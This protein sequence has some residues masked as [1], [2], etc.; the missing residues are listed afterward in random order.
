MITF[1]KF[2]L[3]NFADCLIVTD[4]KIARLYNI[5]GDNVYLLPQGETAKSFTQAEKL[6]EWFLEKNLQR[7]GCI[8]AVGGGSVGDVVGFACSVYKRGAVKLIHAP[9]TL[10]AQI[11]S[12]IGGKTAV[13]VGNVKNAAGSFYSADTVIDEDFLNTLDN[14]QLTSG[15]GELLK[16]RMLSHDVDK[17]FGGNVTK[18]VIE[19]CVRYKQRICDIDLR[20]EKERRVLNFGHT[21]GHGLE[22]VYGISHGAA[23]ANGIYYE[24]LIALK[25]GKCSEEYFDKWTAEVK[26]L[27]TVYPVA[28]DVVSFL[29]N[30]KK[31]A[32]GRICFVLPSDFKQVYL[33]KE[34]VEQLLCCD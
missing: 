4:D 29:L 24:T 8:L 30:D 25:L 12:S 26:K 6:C 1:G 16:Y 31:N 3:D 34:Q 27:F 33:E 18:Q 14:E 11:D 28:R 13:D 9:T 5:T 21:V 32:D 20:D 17:A 10:L 23:V 19:A 22:L 2:Q 15:M 7:G